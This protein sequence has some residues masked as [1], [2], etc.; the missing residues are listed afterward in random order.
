LK[1]LSELNVKLIDKNEITKE[2]PEIG[3]GG[4]GKVYKGKYQEFDV[5]I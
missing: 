2:K 4:Y 5:A 3:K 1:A